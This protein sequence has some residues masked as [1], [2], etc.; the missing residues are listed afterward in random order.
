MKRNVGGYDRIGRFVIGAVLVLAGITG[1]AG[2]FRIALGPVPQALTALVLI[3][4]GAILL[5]TGATQ[6][7]LIHSVVGLD[8]SRSDG[9]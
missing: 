3:A 2:L 6:K 5:V 7:C 4:I 1:Y 8:T 9:K